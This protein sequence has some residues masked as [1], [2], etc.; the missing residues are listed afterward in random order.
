MT[1]NIFLIIFL[2]LGILNFEFSRI[3]IPNERHNIWFAPYIY[4]IYIY[5][6]GPNHKLCLSFVAEI[7][8]NSKF[9]IPKHRKIVKKIFFVISC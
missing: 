3:F 4:Y 7:R 6:Y 8:E 9:N 1:K 5:I 2:C